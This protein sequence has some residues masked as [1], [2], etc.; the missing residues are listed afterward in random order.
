MNRVVENNKKTYIFAYTMVL[1]DSLGYLTLYNLIKLA[2][3]FQQ[4]QI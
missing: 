2:Q 3:V 4:L 1:M